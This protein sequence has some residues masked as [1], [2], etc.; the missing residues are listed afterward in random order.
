MENLT[1]IHIQNRFILINNASQN[2]DDFLNNEKKF[3]RLVLEKSAQEQKRETA[4]KKKMLAK[5]RSRAD[6]LDALIERLY[7]DNI[8]GKLSDERYGKM[9]ARFEAEQ[10]EL[11]QACKILEAEVSEQEETADGIGK[12]L[13]TVRRYTT[14][15]EKL[16][17]AVVH[18][19]IDRIII[20]E[21]ESARKDRRQKVDIIYHRIGAVDLD[22]WQNA[23]A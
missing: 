4:A 16:T 7:M 5:S 23:N 19:F 10:A 14:E 21:A 1:R 20:H 2:F 18:E 8:S 22:E 3:L 13:D 11:V 12:F 6:E 15:I 17:P 9:S